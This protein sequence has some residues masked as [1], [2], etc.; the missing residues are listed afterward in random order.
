LSFQQV[1]DLSTGQL[2]SVTSVTPVCSHGLTYFLLNNIIWFGQNKSDENK[3]QN[4]LT[5]ERTK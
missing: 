3:I 4:D 5:T 2:C 1:E